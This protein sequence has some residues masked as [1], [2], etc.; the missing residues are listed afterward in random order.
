MSESESEDFN[1]KDG[2]EG[3]LGASLLKVQV[4]LERVSKHPKDISTKLQ[5]KL[6]FNVYQ[7]FQ[8]YN[9]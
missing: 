3:L 6:Y 9:R 4:F 1:N 5:L 7:K 8:A 2:I